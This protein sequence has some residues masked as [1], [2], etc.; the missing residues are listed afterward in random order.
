VAELQR[1]QERL[2]VYAAQA[3]MAIAQLYDRAQLASRATTPEA[4]DAKR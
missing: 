4:G 2:D 1:Q 3:R